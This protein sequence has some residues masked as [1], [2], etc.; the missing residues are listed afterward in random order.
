MVGTN[1]WIAH[2]YLLNPGSNGGKTHIPTLCKTGPDGQEVQATTNEEKSKI[3]AKALFPPPP[4]VSTVPET[5]NLLPG[6]HFRGRPGR[7]TK[8]SLHLLENTIRHAW[9]Q[10][11]VVSALFLDIEGAFPNTVTDRLIHNMKVCH[12]PPEII[13]YTERM[14]WGRKTKLCF[15][16]YTSEWFDITNGI[17][18]GD[19]LSMI[20]Y[21]IYNSDL[22]ET[23]KGKHELT[24]AFVDDTAFLAIGKMFQETHSILKDMLER[25]G[26]GFE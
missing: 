20:L 4:A 19:P 8:D 9:R 16:D 14:L 21:I 1:I 10:K 11:K 24:L 25:R 17:G 7:S 12:L 6:T 22:V 26:G 5:H 15:D 3:L 18:Q 2:K 13:T 23:A